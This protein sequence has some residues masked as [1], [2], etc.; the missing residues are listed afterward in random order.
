MTYDFR[1]NIVCSAPVSKGF[2]FFFLKGSYRRI[3]H[4]MSGS[5]AKSRQFGDVERDEPVGM[6]ED[7]TLGARPMM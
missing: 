5:E 6:D 7:D 3:L 1:V 4:S 2:F